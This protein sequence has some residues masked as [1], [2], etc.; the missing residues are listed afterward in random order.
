MM[1]QRAVNDYQ[2]GIGVGGDD[3]SFEFAHSLLQAQPEIF[4]DDAP[5]LMD[6]VFGMT[7]DDLACGRRRR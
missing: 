3:R 6:V 5:G 4:G 2:R 1:G 7:G